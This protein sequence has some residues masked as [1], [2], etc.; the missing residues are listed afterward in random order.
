[1]GDIVADFI[2]TDRGRFARGAG[3]YSLFFEWGVD[4]LWQPRINIG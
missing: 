3:Y 1:M 2:W 4:Y